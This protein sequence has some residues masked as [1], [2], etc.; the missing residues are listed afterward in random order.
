MELIS[1]YSSDSEQAFNLTSTDLDRRDKPVSI[2]KFTQNK[3]DQ[4]AD[5][6]V[7]L[8]KNRKKKPYRLKE[9]KKA[10]FYFNKKTIVDKNESWLHKLKTPHLRIAKEYSKSIEKPIIS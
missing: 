9:G 7:D 1:T 2:A 5:S 10:E 6:S 4:C 3:T 8:L